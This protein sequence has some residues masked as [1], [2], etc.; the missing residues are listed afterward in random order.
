MASGVEKLGGA[1]RP[2]LSCDGSQSRFVAEGEADGRLVRAVVAPVWAL[3][4][5]EAPLSQ[6]GWAFLKAEA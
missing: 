4:E 1:W 5:A 2:Q 3:A 6:P